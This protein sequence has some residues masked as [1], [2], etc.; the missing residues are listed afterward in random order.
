MNVQIAPQPLPM[1]ASFSYGLSMEILSS[2]V[3]PDLLS[4]RTVD[5]VMEVVCRAARK[6]TGADGATFV[7][8]DGDQCHY[9]EEDAIAPLWK[10]SRFP[11]RI[12]IS[13]WVMMNRAPVVIEDIFADPRIPVDAYRPTFVRSLAMV[14]IS[15]DDPVG[16]IGNY[17][18]RPH[19]ALP[20][21]LQLLKSLAK[22]GQAALENVRVYEAL[23]LDLTQR[24]AELDAV[25]REIR[26]RS[27]TEV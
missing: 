20:E 6:L 15:V 23:L 16:A 2:E 10:G 27:A 18:A 1:L 8:R 11:M 12:C 3:L 17:W 24:N 4:A 21:Q 25:R 19:R 7:L 14:P 13:G 26:Q 5:R 22:A 9:A